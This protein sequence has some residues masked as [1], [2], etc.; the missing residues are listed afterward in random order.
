MNPRRV[1]IWLWEDG[2]QIVR[3]RGYWH[4]GWTWPFAKFYRTDWR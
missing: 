1:N 3:P 2:I 4:L